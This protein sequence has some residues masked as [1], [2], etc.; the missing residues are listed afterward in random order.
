MNNLEAKQEAI[1]NAYGE[2]WEKVKDYVD[3]NGYIDNSIP[4]FT[5]GQVKNLDL[6][7][8]NDVLF[9]PKSLQGIENNNGW[10]KIES[11]KDLPKVSGL[12]FGKDYEFG[13]DMMYFD[14]ET[15]KWEDSNGYL[16]N[17]THYQPIKK[18]KPPIY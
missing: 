17:V 10:I 16:Q 12:Y 9:R 8:K 13:T 1:K 4:K 7:Y 6:E 18:S 11:E 14:F 15:K 5:F 2:Y 3:N